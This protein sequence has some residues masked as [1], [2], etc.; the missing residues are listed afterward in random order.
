[1]SSPKAMAERYFCATAAPGTTTSIEETMEGFGARRFRSQVA[2][3]RQSQPDRSLCPPKRRSVLFDMQV[4]EWSFANRFNHEPRRERSC[5]CT[6]P[7][8]CSTRRPAKRGYS[9][10]PFEVLPER[11]QDQSPSSGSDKGKSS[12]T[13]AKIRKKKT[14]SST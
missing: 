1:M 12:S 5:F 9:L 13:S 14:P 2:A 8:S 6:R 11:R 10:L 7:K 4:S 3:R